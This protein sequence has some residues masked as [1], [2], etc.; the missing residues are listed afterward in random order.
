MTT[1]TEEFEINYSP[2]CGR[3]ERD[4][5]SIEIFIYADSDGRWILEVD[6][7]DGICTIWDDT[8]AND[9]AALDELTRTIDEEGIQSLIGIPEGESNH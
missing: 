8:F 6:D 1:D 3:L 4:G 7:E 9:Q 5:E 2:L